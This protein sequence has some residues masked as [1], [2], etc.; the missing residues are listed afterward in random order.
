MERVTVINDVELMQDATD[1]NKIHFET[2]SLTVRLQADILQLS[3]QA[4]II[5]QQLSYMPG[6]EKF[7]RISESS[8][9]F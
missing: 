2:K 5:K 9:P 8:Q 7:T 1:M 4:G 3:F 6:Y